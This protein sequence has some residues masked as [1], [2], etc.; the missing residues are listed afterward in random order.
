MAEMV[1]SN[2]R[3][4]HEHAN[5]A[6]VR[7]ARV[8]GYRSRAAYKLMQIDDRDRLLKPGSTI[9]DLG[10]APGGWSQVA[11]QRIGSHG[12]ILALDKLSIAPIFDVEIIQGDFTQPDTVAALH[13]SL[14]GMPVHTVMSDMA[15][16]TSGI[17]STDQ[18][19]AMEL[20]EAVVAFAQGILK[21]D[22]NLLIKVFQGEGCDHFRMQLRT[23]FRHIATR[24]PKASRA[25]SSELYLLARGFGV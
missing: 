19:L 3:W 13:K 8:Q 18:S 12:R 25:R 14:Q 15:P 10:A 1:R 22:G 4:V 20:A 11:A 7:Q 23:F 2:Q 21:P 6:Y 9:V 16:V 17:K 5:D 24:K